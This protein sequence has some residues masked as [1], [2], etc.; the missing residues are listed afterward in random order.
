MSLAIETKEGREVAVADIPGAYLHADVDEK[1][2]VRFDG[3]MVEML[4]RI[5]SKIY[6]PYVQVGRNGQLILY[7]EFKKLYM[8]VHVLVYCSGGTWSL[9]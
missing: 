9:S 6:K 1:I 4:V 2:I 8:D 5:E 3:T 7:T